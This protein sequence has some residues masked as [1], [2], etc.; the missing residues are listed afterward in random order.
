MAQEQSAA[1]GTS[2]L[3]APAVATVSATA[4][5][6]DGA[7]GVGPNGPFR[8]TVT[9][10]R[11]TSV[12]LAKPD[13]TAI[14]ATPTAD[15]RTWAVTQPLG[16]GKTYTWIAQ[17]I[18]ADG[19]RSEVRSSFTTLRPARQLSAS[20][21]VGDNQTYGVAMPIS[22]TFN[23]PV[24]DRA[25]A[26]R[27]LSVTA[28]VPT[29][30]AWGWTDNRT[31]HYRTK[32]YWQPGTK[33][34]VRANLYGVALGRGAY[35]AS[36]VS[37]AFTIGRAQI[38]Q[39]NTQTHRLVVIRDGQQVADYPASYGLD[40]DPGRVTH[41]GTHVVL[42]KQDTYSMSNPKYNYH[43]VVV[44]WAVRISNNGE[45]IHG[46]AG[47]IPEQG[48]SNVSHGCANLSP[49]N[50]K[51]YFDTAMVGDPVEIVGSSL[52]LSAADGDYYDWAIPWAQWLTMSAR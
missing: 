27:A 15:R 5:P 11:F 13:G 49:A 7:T 2:T 18:G 8:F 40:A 17:A 39:G 42:S 52:T 51:Q 23:A 4:T 41:S 19:A 22:L 3:R 34:A 24:T 16:Y 32:N 43:D 12:A 37:A 26:E 29:E 14:A 1:A 20:L 46:Y 9:K 30:G 44:P 50:A 36:D 38:V 48:K 31:V 6:A 25:A 21:S 33:V 47:S 45:F 28:S 10:G 35:G